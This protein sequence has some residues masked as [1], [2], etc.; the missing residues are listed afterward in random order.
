MQE[1]QPRI[2]VGGAL[3]G[4]LDQRG[5][6][7]AGKVQKTLE[8]LRLLVRVHVHA[9]R[10]LH[11]LP[12]HRLGVG[13]FHDAGRQGKEFGK[14]R[15]TEAPCPCNDLEA[16]CVRAYGNGLDEAVLPN[17]FGKLLQL[18][19]LEGLAWVGGGLVDGVN[20]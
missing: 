19:R 11:Q 13:K 10:I 8:A 17:A 5:Y 4:L 14:L 12:L 15:G 2:D 3:A 1:T 9:L 18:A 20:R 16:V 6:V 7:I